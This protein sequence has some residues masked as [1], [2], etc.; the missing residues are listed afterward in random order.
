MFNQKVLPFAHMKEHR[1]INPEEET[2][3][4]RIDRLMDESFAI[5][6]TGVADSA[7]HL[8]VSAGAHDLRPID[9]DRRRDEKYRQF[10]AGTH[11]ETVSTNN[12]WNLFT[13]RTLQS[14]NRMLVELREIDHADDYLKLAEE[15]V[16]DRY[17]VYWT[18][19]TFYLLYTDQMHKAL[20]KLGPDKAEAL[21][22]GA[23]HNE[24]FKWPDSSFTAA[25]IEPYLREL[26]VI[27][28]EMGLDAAAMDD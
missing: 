11:S 16:V 9:P 6:S 20:E 8:L 1:K 10:K 28:F 17:S 12:L 7:I 2:S 21:L 26:Y 27:F 4:A 14:I 13:D 19:K 3:V 25:N 18:A 22:K 5:D 24:T 23:R 15:E